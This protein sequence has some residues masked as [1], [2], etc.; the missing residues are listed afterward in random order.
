MN[1]PCIVLPTGFPYYWQQLPWKDC[2]RTTLYR[3]DGLDLPATQ[4]G[5]VHYLTCLPVNLPPLPY[6]PVP[7]LIPCPNP[8]AAAGDAYTTHTP[9]THCLLA[10]AWRPVDLP[11]IL[12]FLPAAPATCHF[13]ITDGRTHMPCLLPCNLYQEPASVPPSAMTY[14]LTC[15]LVP[16]MD[17]LFCCLPVPSPRMDRTD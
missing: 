11:A 17:G 7:C 4:H 13:A 1:L 2:G 12:C 8:K 5:S 9:H 16:A 15:Y 14:Y 10:A 6:V 3:R